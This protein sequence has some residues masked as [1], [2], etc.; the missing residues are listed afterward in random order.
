M[1]GGKGFRRMNMFAI[2]ARLLILRN[3]I[4]EKLWGMLFLVGVEGSGETGRK[5]NELLDEGYILESVHEDWDLSEYGTN[6]LVKVKTDYNET[7]MQRKLPPLCWYQD[8]YCDNCYDFHHG[9]AIET[10]MRLVDAADLDGETGS[11]TLAYRRLNR[12]RA[13]NSIAARREANPLAWAARK[14]DEAVSKRTDR[15]IGN[16]DTYGALIRQE[17]NE[18]QQEIFET[19]MMRLGENDE[20]VEDWRDDFETWPTFNEQIRSYSRLY[21]HQLVWY[22]PPVTKVRR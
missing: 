18:E 12:V 17:G 15:A 5:W 16:L 9:N 7:Q 1:P 19:Q 6:I 2:V 8:C 14:C 10:G 3:A 22:P 13:A 21:R 4:E 11:V 20:L